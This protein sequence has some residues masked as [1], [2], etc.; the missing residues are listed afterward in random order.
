MKKNYL[1]ANLVSVIA[2]SSC[3]SVITNATTNGVFYNNGDIP[4]YVYKNRNNSFAV[5]QSLPDKIALKV[6]T[7]ILSS[8]FPNEKIDKKELNFIETKNFNTQSNKDSNLRKGNLLGN[9]ITNLNHSIENDKNI[10]NPNDLNF[11]GGLI[12]AE[13]GE[14]KTKNSSVGVV[15]VNDKDNAIFTSNLITAKV[16]NPVDQNIQTLLEKYKAELISRNDNYGTVIT[17]KPAVIMF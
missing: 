15:S 4:E 17:I 13:Y 9:N 3:S 11:L 6:D 2:I 14:I 5:K 10:F 12:P 7:S 8:V 16:L 1:F